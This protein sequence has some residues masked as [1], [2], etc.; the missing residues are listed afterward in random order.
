MN[1]R[2]IWIIIAVIVVLAIVAYVINKNSSD[3]NT[4]G[5]QVIDNSLA[6]MT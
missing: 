1:R 5:L 4:G 2:T 6:Y 3:G